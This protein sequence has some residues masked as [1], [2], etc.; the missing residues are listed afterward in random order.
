MVTIMPIPAKPRPGLAATRQDRPNDQC[1]HPAPCGGEC[2]LTSTV[3]HT[4][5]GCN[6]RH[7]IACHSGATHAANMLARRREIAARERAALKADMGGLDGP[8]F[9]GFVVEGLEY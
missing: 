7:C 5:H 1:L 8:E 3:R 6:D 4:I 2:A 9:M